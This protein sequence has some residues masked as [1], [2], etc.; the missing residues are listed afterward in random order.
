MGDMTK[1]W[2]PSDEA[3]H[4]LPTGDRQAFRFRTEK[5]CLCGVTSN[6]DHRSANY[7]TACGSFRKEKKFFKQ[8]RAPLADRSYLTSVREHCEL[9]LGDQPAGNRDLAKLFNKQAPVAT[10]AAKF[11]SDTAYGEHFPRRQ[12]TLQHPLRNQELTQRQML[13]RSSPGL[14]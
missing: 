10:S 9:P 2:R 5:E 12:L 7:A 8:N 3:I 13:S 14:S 4:S 6:D 11:A 1:V